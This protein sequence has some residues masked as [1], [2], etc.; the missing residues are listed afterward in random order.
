MLSPSSSNVWPP[1]NKKKR[2]KC[3]YM[4][5]HSISLSLNTNWS[6]SWVIGPNC[7]MAQLLLAHTHTESTKDNK[8]RQLVEWIQMMDQVVIKKRTQTQ[9]NPNT[10]IDTWAII[11]A[12]HPIIPYFSLHICFNT[13]YLHLSNYT[14]HSYC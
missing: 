8:N 3:M 1:T 12:N 13:L 6:L 5:W 2:T 7:T 11:K 14:N 4:F 10:V 9:K